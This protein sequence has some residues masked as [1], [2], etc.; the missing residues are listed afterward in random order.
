[1]I[2]FGANS[3]GQ[4]AARWAFRALARLMWLSQ[5]LISAIFL[6][7]I[8]VSIFGPKFHWRWVPLFFLLLGLLFWGV[9]FLAGWF[10]RM[11][12]TSLEAMEAGRTPQRAI[13]VRRA[14]KSVRSD[15]LYD[16]EVDRGG[17]S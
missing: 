10:A 11:S 3:I 14:P 17:W 7:S 13:V 5:Y 6:I 1:M 8:L 16:A 15:P 2:Q 12:G 4:T 9:R